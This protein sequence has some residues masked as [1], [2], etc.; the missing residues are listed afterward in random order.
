[1]GNREKEKRR[2]NT[3][4]VRILLRWLG[5]LGCGGGVWGAGRVAVGKF[6]PHTRWVRVR[7]CLSI[8][9]IYTNFV[10]SKRG[11]PTYSRYDKIARGLSI[12]V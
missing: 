4:M 2:G 11:F 8:K 3:A 12:Y 10:R 9:Q 1:M 7:Y 6:S 5:S